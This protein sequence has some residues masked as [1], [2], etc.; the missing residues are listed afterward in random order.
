MKVEIL[1]V[2][3]SK[4]GDLLC[5]KLCNCALVKYDFNFRSSRVG[6]L[7]VS[8]TVSGRMSLSVEEVRDWDSVSWSL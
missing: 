7:T 5:E 1:I 6:L 4:I 8:R 2:P 3:A